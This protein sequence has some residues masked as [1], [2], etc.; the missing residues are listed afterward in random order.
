MS[1][2]KK[3]LRDVGRIILGLTIF[4]LGVHLTIF[5][6]IGLAPWDCLGMGI[7]G[8]SPLSYGL[9]M[10][11][12]SVTILLIDLL[13]RERIGFGTV[14]DALLTGNL[15]Q[16][17]ND[18]NPLPLNTSLPL[19]ALLMT[20]GMALMAVGMRIYMLP[21]RGCGPRDALLV[22]LGKQVRRVPIGAVQ[23]ALLVSAVGAGWLLGG[24]VGPG[25]LLFMALFGPEMQLI[26]HWIG[27]EPR[28]IRHRSVGEDLAMLLGNNRQET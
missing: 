1:E 20:A 13:L 11:A 26:Y 22:G 9:S 8:H 23:M 3:F 24:P 16:L 14:I 25:T 27:F 28:D 4:A 5:A 21:G 7:A 2:K 15:I 18:L 12:V 19:G 10:T 17:F 6:N